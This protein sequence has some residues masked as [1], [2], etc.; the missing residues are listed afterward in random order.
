MQKNKKKGWFI[1]DK[2]LAYVNTLVGSFLSSMNLSQSQIVCSFSLCSNPTCEDEP[3]YGHGE[4]EADKRF[5]LM[6]ENI[7]RKAERWHR[8]YVFMGQKKWDLACYK[9]LDLVDSAYLLNYRE[10]CNLKITEYPI[11]F[12]TS[13]LLLTICLF[14]LDTCV[15]LKTYIAQPSSSLVLF[16]KNLNCFN[17]NEIRMKE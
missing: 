16:R 3:T 8:F 6:K 15:S 11:W 1:E 7:Y 4:D 17:C 9:A 10:K 12:G 2:G 14:L 5:V 13:N